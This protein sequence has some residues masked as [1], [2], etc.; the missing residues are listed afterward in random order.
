MRSGSVLTI[1]ALGLL[2]GTA[3][4]Q[5]AADPAKVALIQRLL[6]VTK[7]VELA[8]TAIETSL[9]AQR[10]ANPQ[11][12]SEFWDEFAKRARQDI[13]RFVQ[14]LIPIYDR[15]FTSA[16]LKELLA[17]YQTP[18]GQHFIKVQPTITVQSIQAGQQWGA[19]LGAEVAQDLQKRGVR[20]PPE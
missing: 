11:I 12:P 15:Q 19:Q 5:A 2:A 14:L 17:F 7:S 13:P 4:A 1:L 16:Q 9:P 20:V 6:D 8:V 18:L 10:Q 3:H